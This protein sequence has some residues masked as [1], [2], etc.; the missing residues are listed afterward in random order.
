MKVLRFVGVG[1]L[2][3]ALLASAA[4]GQLL[5]GEGQDSGLGGSNIIYGQLFLSSG[6]RLFKRVQIRVRTDMRGDRVFMT[7]EKGAY[8]IRGLPTGN[9]TLMVEKEAEFEPAQIAFELVVL[10]GLPAAPTNINI[11]LK[12]KPGTSIKPAVVNAQF[13]GV[14]Q[15]ALDLYTKGVELAKANDSAG[16]IE[17]FKLA[18][19][20]HPAF[21]QAFN[22]MGVQ[23]LRLG[24]FEKAD[25]AF[26]RS[27]KITPDSFAP[28]MN[29]G[30]ALVNLK[31]YADAEPVLRDAAKLEPKSPVVNYFLGQ[32]LANLGK[33]EEAD[34]KLSAAVKDGG[35]EM[36]EAR[37]TLAIIYSSWGQKEKAAKELEEYLKVAPNSPDAAQLRQLIAQFR[38]TPPK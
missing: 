22:E 24:E 37:R 33:F 28:L 31:K 10:R 19:A 20:E 30:I 7:D 13:A 26:Q 12:P 1:F 35:P 23:H 11:T 32:A 27:L 17:Q 34:T 14:P 6:E 3:I 29:R 9:F 4:F 5:P 2:G 15:A 16:A 38:Q 8:V 18:V 25:E 36:K 21:A